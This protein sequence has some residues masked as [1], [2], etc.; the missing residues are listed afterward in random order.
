[1]VVYIS[2]L[3]PSVLGQVDRARNKSF[4]PDTIILSIELTKTELVKHS[5][6]ANKTKVVK[7][8]VQ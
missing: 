2:A 1:M 5:Y 3:G 4:V 8:N 7:P 6:V